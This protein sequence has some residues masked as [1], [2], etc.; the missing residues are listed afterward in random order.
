VPFKPVSRF[1]T[2]LGAY[3]EG[4]AKELHLGRLY[5]IVS[6]IPGATTFR[7]ASLSIMT[8]SIASLSI[9]T[10][11]IKDSNAALSNNDNEHSRYSA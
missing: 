8:L 6:A 1:R 3:P 2:R 9:M 10:I 7:I 4:R 11:G 5:Q